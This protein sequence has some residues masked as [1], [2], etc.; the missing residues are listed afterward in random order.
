MRASTNISTKERKTITLSN[1]RGVDLS[2]SKYNVQTNRATKMRNLI[3]QNGVNQKRKGWNQ[4]YKIENADRI[5][6][7]IKMLYR[8]TFE[9]QDYFLVYAGKK[10]YKVEDN[11]KITDITLSGYDHDSVLVPPSAPNIVNEEYLIDEKCQV[12]MNNGKAYI[13]GCGDYL[14]YGKWK[15]GYYALRRVENNEDT[16][17]PT[18]T[19]SID[20][21]GTKDPARS[22]LD[23]ENI[24]SPYR[25]NT[26]VGITGTTGEK[27]END[28]YPRTE[29]LTYMLDSSI[30]KDSYVY[31]EVETSYYDTIRKERRTKTYIC[32]NS[33]DNK[34]LLYSKNISIGETTQVGEIYWGYSTEFSFANAT[35]TFNEKIDLT[36]A[37]ENSSNIKIKFETNRDSDATNIITK[38][39]FGAEFGADGN[40]DRLFLSGNADK[41]NVDIYSESNDY[42]YFSPLNTA[43]MGNDSS[44]IMGYSRLSDSTLVVFKKSR[45]QEATIFYRTGY[46]DKQYDS[47][48]NLISLRA[49]FPVTAGS[50]GEGLISSYALGNL[51]GDSLMLSENGVFG[52]VLT[53]N[54]STNERYT[55][56][57]SRSID[58]DLIKHD[59]SKAIGIVYKNK[60]YLAVDN[61][62]YV[63]D[64]RFKYTTQEDIDYNY[65]WWYWDNMPVSIFAIHN[66]KL[67]FGTEDGRI[68]IFDEEREDRKYDMSQKGDLSITYVSN[69]VVSNQAFLDMLEEGNTIMFTNDF[70]YAIFQENITLTMDNKIVMTKP[71]EQYFE[72]IEVYADNVGN[73]GL[74]INTK[75]YIINVDRGNGTYELATESGD[76]VN[77]ASGGF[78]LHKNIAGRELAFRKRQYRAFQVKEIG[79]EEVLQLT[80]Y[81]GSPT[82]NLM[83]RI[84]KAEPVV[85]EWESAIMSL[86]TNVYSKTLY[87][88]TI[89]TDREIGGQLQFGYET[90]SNNKILQRNNM[91]DVQ[92]INMF[93]FDDFSFDNFTFGGDFASSYTVKVKERNFNYIMLKFKSSNNKNCAVDNITMTYKINS[94]NK[95][96]M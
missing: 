37:I 57:R 93:S 71:I 3:N 76:I 13:V 33:Q 91:L 65:E 47:N 25:Y 58:S 42:T 7:G 27:N 35:I 20:A 45:G 8:Y 68:C 32:A 79:A 30:K 44:P 51:A 90:A 55:R 19:I 96:V 53:S 41:P 23:D 88:L 16:Y 6:Q 83:A 66:D 52:I 18:T 62:C 86:G 80:Q 75:Y 92:G 15:D 70:V 81:N 94:F 5:G 12:F 21:N 24:L 59:L 31:I 73:S 84:R 77:L 39:M 48:N 10:F 82:T 17:I 74:Q 64:S 63:A 72:G 28:N 56:N 26:C 69:D 1:F 43:V 87:K 89:C 14:V 11:G 61:V 46:Y 40:T 50:A 22:S 78:N 38:C 34:K 4:V 95:G 36:P 29:S 54:V 2:S 67:Y 85:A 9:D 49:I 60:Y